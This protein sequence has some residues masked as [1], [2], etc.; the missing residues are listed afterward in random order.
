MPPI[1]LCTSEP[2]HSLSS[3]YPPLQR[4][5]LTQEA[6][7]PS[8]PSHHRDLPCHAPRNWASPLHPAGAGLSPSACYHQTPYTRAPAP[9]THLVRVSLYTFGFLHLFG[10]PTYL[11]SLRL[12]VSLMSRLPHRPLTSYP[13]LYVFVA[14]DRSWPS[15]CIP[16]YKLA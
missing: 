2:G 6:R 12:T 7:P 13:K 1:C 14:T 9:T 11:P 4:I 10:F 8:T 16:E 5:L 15:A 3:P